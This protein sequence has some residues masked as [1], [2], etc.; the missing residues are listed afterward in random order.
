MNGFQSRQ[1]VD[2]VLC[3][4]YRFRNAACGAN[5]SAQESVQVLFPIRSDEWL[6]ILGAEDD[7]Q[8]DAE[9]CRGH[10]YGAPPGRRSFRCHFQG[11]GAPG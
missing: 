1:D 2:V 7:V 4:T 3:A 9:M 6:A 5:R 10:L 8:M 11:R